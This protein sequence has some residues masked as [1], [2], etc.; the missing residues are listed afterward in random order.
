MNRVY[1]ANFG[2]GN[3]LWPNARTNNTII[4]ITDRLHSN[5]TG[6]SNAALFQTGAGAV[7]EPGTWAM[8]LFGFGAIGASLRRRRKPILQA[9]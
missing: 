4:T 9:A 8:M 7:P 2:E 6:L 1:I 3:A 5:A